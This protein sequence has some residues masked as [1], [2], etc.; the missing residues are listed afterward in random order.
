MQVCAF[1]GFLRI[2]MAAAVLWFAPSA[3]FHVHA[4]D[5]VLVLPDLANPYK[6]HW[7]YG[8][9][10]FYVDGENIVKHGL[11]DNAKVTIPY[12]NY[13][14]RN[15][16]ARHNG[17]FLTVLV[18]D[19]GERFAP[20]FWGFDIRFKNRFYAGIHCMFETGSCKEIVRN[21]AVMT[22]FQSF[23]D[24]YVYG[25]TKWANYNDTADIP[26][27][28]HSDLVIRA[29]NTREKRYTPGFGLP[30]VYV[31]E[32]ETLFVDGYSLPK[33]QAIYTSAVF[34]FESDA[35]V[36]I[37]FPGLDKDYDLGFKHY[38]AFQTNGISIIY[39]SIYY[40]K[41]TRPC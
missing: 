23:E 35:F 6:P 22:G 10:I 1:T 40:I 12:G 36:N 32:D 28:T 30:G 2:A 4:Q 26:G 20:N 9:H 38:V 17:V 7:I 29:K 13:K 8:D 37:E 21:R 14:V 16:I 41:Q 19:K 27:P 24:G 33:G 3:S 31:S 25:W 39:S 5:V 15:L 18:L 11:H 34:R